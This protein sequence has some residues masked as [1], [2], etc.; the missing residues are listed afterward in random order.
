M[1][2]ERFSRKINSGYKAKLQYSQREVNIFKTTEQC[3]KQFTFSNLWNWGPASSRSNI[4][5]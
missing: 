2:K 5:I 1:L 4:S 3:R